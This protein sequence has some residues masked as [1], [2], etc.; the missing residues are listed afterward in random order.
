M[1]IFKRF[2]VYENPQ[3]TPTEE[4]LVENK[5]A[6]FFYHSWLRDDAELIEIAHSILENEGSSNYKMTS[7][8]AEV[9]EALEFFS[10]EN[11]DNENDD[12][13]YEVLNEIL[14]ELSG[15]ITELYNLSNYICGFIEGDWGLFPSHMLE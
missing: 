11:D 5:E 13:S 3:L 10:Y 4:Q 6:L 9:E 2:A 12:N 7:I 15:M 14:Y 8:Y 1:T